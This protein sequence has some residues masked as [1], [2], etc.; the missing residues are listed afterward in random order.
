VLRL[1]CRDLRARRIAYRTVASRLALAHPDDV[2]RCC[3]Q[4]ARSHGIDF[5]SATDRTVLT[6]AMIREMQDSGLVEFGAHSVHHARL[7]RLNDAEA[8]REIAGSKSD[9][10]ALVGQQVRHFAYPYGDAAAAGEREAAICS[11]IGLSSAV[12]TESRTIFASDAAR[13]FALPRLTFK[14]LIPFEPQ[15]DLLLSGTL[16]A[17]RRQ[18]HTWRARVGYAG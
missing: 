14:G 2:R 11:E 7:G 9:C 5:M 12:T 13:P 18:W 17:A 10:E 1:S 4:L 16:P 3:E 15:L 8:Y 6:P